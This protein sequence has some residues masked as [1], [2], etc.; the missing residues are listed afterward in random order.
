MEATS[1][2]PPQSIGAM[3]IPSNFLTATMLFSR[4]ESIEKMPTNATLPQSDDVNCHVFVNSLFKLEENSSAFDSLNNPPRKPVVLY[5]EAWKPTASVMANAG[6]DLHNIEEE[7]DCVKPLQSEELNHESCQ[8]QSTVCQL[9]RE[10]ADLSR[11]ALDAKRLSVDFQNQF[12]ASQPVANNLSDLVE[13]Q[14]KELRESCHEI[15]RLKS[16][17]VAASQFANSTLNE[18]FD[19]FQMDHSSNGTI[20]DARQEIER[21]R[22][23]VSLL[24]TLAKEAINP[25]SASG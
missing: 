15:S 22:M 18:G 23:A 25:T 14:K 9:D 7:F 3:T 2:P 11:V 12:I 17:L 6:V 13:T 19:W 21:L 24:A 20:D 8:A 1:T 5:D 10:L 16:L 4:T